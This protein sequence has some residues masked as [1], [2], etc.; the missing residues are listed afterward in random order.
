MKQET[1]FYIALGTVVDE[2]Q[3][4]DFY[5]SIIDLAETTRQANQYAR[6]SLKYKAKAIVG[7]DRTMDR[8]VKE[9]KLSPDQIAQKIMALIHSPVMA[10]LRWSAKNIATCT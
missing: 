7:F 3:K 8:L 6:W 1:M 10:C 5:K 4:S 9:L 2:I